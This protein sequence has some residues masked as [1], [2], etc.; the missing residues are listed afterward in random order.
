M[1][2]GADNA[3][4]SLPTG[5]VTFLFTDVESSTRLWRHVPGAGTLMSR[6]AEIIA[7]AISRHN[8][9]RPL[10]QGEGDSVVAAFARASN[11]LAAA[12]DAQRALATEPWPEGAALRVR[13][14]VH[15]GEAELRDA[16]NYGGTAI[17]RGARLRTLAR[18]GQVLVS[19]TTVELVR[20]NLPAG[21]TLADL[22]SFP[23]KGFE[24]PER[25]HQLCHPDLA[26]PLLTA[27][28]SV[29]SALPL[30]P[31]PLVGR[32]RERAEVAE[33][34]AS[35]RVLTI[36]GAGGSGKTRLAH[37]VAEDLMERWVDGVV[38]V[39]LSRLSDE[40]QVA[41]TVLN[42]CGAQEVPGA[43]ALDVLTQH[44]AGAQ[45]LIIFDNCEHLLAT[46]ARVADCI[47]RAGDGVTI[48]A[49]SR[50]PLGVSG[51]VTWRIPSLGLP[52]EGE[53]DA[54][55]LL[56]S[57]AIRLFV[58]RARAARPDFTLDPGNA[59]HVSR[60]CRRL[61][62]LPLAL[63]LAAARV[64]A[65]S[66]DRLADGLDDRFRL[67]TGG[68]RTAMA[69]QRTLLASVE[70]SHDLL[71]DQERML[72]RRLGVFAAPFTLEAAEAVTAD[73]ELDR[74]VVF[75]VLARLI[76]KSLVQ[77]TG[78]RYR[79]LE[80]LRQYALER[81]GDAS[82]LVEVRD[83]HL[84]WFVR[85]AESWALDS[86]PATIGGLEEIA[87][88]APDLLS[89]LEWSL[90]PQ[91]R[92]AVPL[93]HPL[94]EHWLYRHAYEEVRVI[95]GR[96]LSTCA[97]GSASWLEA[98][99]P[100]ALP[101]VFAGDLAWLPAA[102]RA[103]DDETKGLPP[104]VRGFIESA[105]SMFPAFGGRPEGVEGLRRALDDARACGSRN[106][107]IGVMA[108][109]AM[110]L[111]QIGDRTNALPLLAWLDRHLPADSPMSFLLVVARA[112]ANT[113][114][115]AFDD[116]IAA[117]RPCF[118][119][120]REVGIGACA[121]VVAFYREDKELAKMAVAVAERCNM[122]GIFE[123]AKWMTVASSAILDC[124]FEAAR[125]ALRRGAAFGT[126]PNQKLWLLCC[127][128]EVELGAGDLA[129]AE[130]LLDEVEA[131][132]E[133]TDLHIITAGSALTRAF[134]ERERG[135]APAAET[136]A[137][138]ALQRALEHELGLVTTDAL[139]ALAILA[140]DGGDTALAGR[141][142]GAAE[143][144]RQR[145]GYRLRHAYERRAIEAIRTR[146]E[147]VHLEEGARLSL[148]EAAE[149]AQRGRG[150][151]GRPN[152]GWDSL[153]PSEQRVVELVAAGL[154]NRDIAAKL[155]VSL[156]TIKTH[157]VHVYTKLDVRTRAELAAA[158]TRREL[159]DSKEQ[160]DV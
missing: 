159:G 63:E 2:P 90:A 25:A 85:R 113:Y 145:T 141:L 80:T 6:Q 40:T 51:E 158:A 4:S 148:Q 125:R 70:W 72:F 76:D 118:E 137:H 140:V 77:H 71:D 58:E 142:L 130:A 5:V 68:A 81:A 37:A 84:A 78:D 102:R 127:H 104:K 39:D 110:L 82:E 106:L 59:T 22:G 98:L 119:E 132:V 43:S 47:A 16:H 151:R 75:D 117:L 62:G 61:D 29:S 157:L 42:S 38:W 3:T 112:L 64:R 17:I 109:L 135:N 144:F 69:R 138:A 111:T 13:M 114:D 124:D 8:G 9:V 101:L 55:R 11:A 28:R 53:N 120:P 65:L 100:V 99:A 131:S 60:I 153:T 83:H 123:A 160:S 147:P 54:D 31:T 108:N 15:T 27:G 18:G 26:M 107:E 96:A 36:T 12:L 7:A 116:A 48:I 57:E 34:L 20:D 128:A 1:S 74:L 87:S 105:A 122:K 150:E 14:A 156:A 56:T 155:F 89:A 19:A 52:P 93:L 149:Y 146:L 46:C 10:E 30:W 143:A 152:H 95:A 50:E 32:T 136:R 91:G 24:R 45:M 21:A 134:T 126:L 129:A 139:E 66:L 92:L 73:D 35:S 79:L 41:G 44:L 86:Q 94:R 23:L 121:A 103:L 88:E 49:T 133:G 33:L 97:E 67:L 154:P 115:G